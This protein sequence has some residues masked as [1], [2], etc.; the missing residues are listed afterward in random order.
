MNMKKHL[1]ILSF[2]NA[3]RDPR[4]YRQ[5]LSLRHEYRVTVAALASPEIEGVDFIPIVH[6]PSRHVGEKLWRA[7]TLLCGFSGPFLNRFALQEPQKT[8]SSH[9]DLVL[10][11]DLEPLPLGFALARTSPV[12]FDAH[13]YYPDEYPDIFWKIFHKSHNTRLCK[14]YVP[15]LAGM[16]TVSPAM[17]KAYA[18]HFRV[19]PDVVYSGPGFQEL[20]VQPLEKDR[21]RMIYHGLAGPERRLEDTIAMM[22]LLDQRFTLDLM[23]LGEEGYLRSLRHASAGH[24]RIQWREPVPMPDICARTNQ[25]DIGVFLIPQNLFNLR[26]TIPN[27]FFEYIQAR[28]AVAAVPAEGITGMVKEHELGVIA[29]DFTPKALAAKLSALTVEDII[30]FKRGADKAAAIYNAEESMKVLKGVLERALE[31]GKA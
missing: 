25:Y 23:L 15:K 28:L 7:G 20:P 3:R 27:K 11:N 5:A 17:A 22:D 1:L 6:K 12:V 29:D 9:F 2:T 18:D 30:R 19:M 14:Q 24:P 26:I 16:T 8:A 4:L 10:V 13:E 21:I 31:K